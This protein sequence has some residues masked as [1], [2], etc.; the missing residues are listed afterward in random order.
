MNWSAFQKFQ[1]KLKQTNNNVLSSIQFG[2]RTENKTFKSK[3][4]S[5]K[6]TYLLYLF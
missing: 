6:I 4:S 3:K 1:G 2:N 5:P